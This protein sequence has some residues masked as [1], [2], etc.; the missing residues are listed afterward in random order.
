VTILNEKEISEAIP[1][2]EALLSTLVKLQM[3]PVLER[4]LQ[5]IFCR[6]LW[7]LTGK[8]TSRD[9]QKKLK[10]GAKRISDTWSRW[11]QAGLITRDGQTYRKV[12]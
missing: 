11:E 9:I 8:A 2:I 5:E 10:C 12:T 4:E 1:R 6:K 7:S 3:A